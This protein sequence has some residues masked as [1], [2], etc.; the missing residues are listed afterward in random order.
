MRAIMILAVVIVAIT[1]L[2]APA[3]Q[4][5]M[6]RYPDNPAHERS[7]W[8]QLVLS[9][10][11]NVYD[12]MALM[13]RDTTLRTKK[14]RQLRR[15]Q[16]WVAQRR[17]HAD[18]LGHVEH[19]VAPVNDVLVEHARRMKMA[20]EPQSSDPRWFG[21]GPF[22]WDTAA[23]RATGS[24]GIGVVRS[25]IVFPDDPGLVIAGTI[26]A[27]I[28]RSSNAGRDW[29]PISH[30]EPI[31]TVNKLAVSG[32]TVYAATNI[33]LY[34][35]ADRGRTFERLS[36]SGDPAVS[37]VVAVD[38]CTVDPNDARRV[39]I[40]AGSRL[41]LSTDAGQSW[42]SASNMIGTWWDLCW[43]PTRSD[44]AYGLVQINGHIY[45]TRSTNAGVKFN[46]T[47]Q[48]YPSER[49]DARMLRALLAVTPANPR[50]VAVMIG[51]ATITDTGGVYG[52]YMSTD[53]GSTFEHRCCGGV[54]GPETPNAV[55]N[56]NLFDYDIAG[57]GLGQITWDMGFAISSTDPDFMI[58]AGIFPYRS[59]DGGRTWSTL[60]AMHYDVQSVSINGDSVW[61]THDGGIT[62]SS[63]RGVSIVD[64]SHGISATEVW[65]FDQSIDGKVMTIGAYHMPI[66]IR[67]TTV[68]ASGA[69]AYGWYPWSGADAMGT[70]VNPIA[71]EWLYAK[72][73][74]SVR[75]RRSTSKLLPPS[76]ADLGIDLGYITRDNICFDPQRY[77]QITAADHE[78]LRLVRS[79][80]NAASWATL[81]QFERWIGRVRQHPQQGRFLMC[82]GDGALWISS[83][84]GQTWEAITPPSGVML[85]QGM[86]DMA[87]DDDDPFHLYVAFG[88]HQ[89]KAK[90]AESTDG[91]R[92][93][94]PLNGELP[95]FTILTLIAR[96]GSRRE[97]YVGTTYGVYRHDAL[98]GWKLFGKDLPISDVSFL[99]A[100]ERNGWLRIGTNRGLWQ[101]QLPP[102]TIPR[103]QISHDI[104]TVRCSLS[105]VMFGCRSAVRQTSKFQR[106]WLFPGG[107]PNRSSD[108]IVAVTYATPGVYDAT[109]IVANEDGADTMHLSQAVVVLR[110]ECDSIDPVRGRA[111]DLSNDADHVTLGRYPRTVASF[112]FMAW[113]K[114]IGRQPNFSAIFCT[115]ADPNVAQEI[116][117]QFANDNNELGY[118]WTGGRWWWGSSLV[119]RPDEWSHVALTID[120]T[121]ATVYVNGRPSKDNI[122]LAPID[123]SKLVFTLGTY[124]Y[125]SSRNF[126]GLIDEVA[127]YDRCLSLEEVRRDMH[128]TKSRNDA[129]LF[130]YFQFN[131][132]QSGTVWDKVGSKHGQ[133]NGGAKNI[134]S[135]APVAA[136]EAELVRVPTGSSAASF[137]V[138]KDSCF[139]YQPPADSVDLVMTRFYQVDDLAVGAPQNILEGSWRIINAFGEIPSVELAELAVSAE[140]K[141]MPTQSG[142]RAWGVLHRSGWSMNDPWTSARIVENASL[143]LRENSVRARADRGLLT[144]LQ[145]LLTYSGTPASVESEC[146][147]SVVVSP[148]PAADVL[149]VRADMELGDIALFD[150]SGRLIMQLA[151]PH[152]RTEQGV[153]VSDLPNGTYILRA[154]GTYRVITVL[155]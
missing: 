112:T 57:T 133:H 143:P 4:S 154:G 124:H 101:A 118:L 84:S 129:G 76:A 83:N 107:Q 80:D 78:Q 139:L 33:G 105:P 55:T 149:Y 114:P 135:T 49:T 68:Y 8:Y 121:G 86:V 58:A 10:H 31:Q 23:V 2:V 9:D 14:S 48:G 142:S 90:V 89:S 65:G 72:P 71:T 64:R 100:D 27:G 79:S 6:S 96:R 155:R 132:G 82:L 85:G 95:P 56:P 75:A 20:E 99:H 61:I 120:S 145:L 44:I 1:P 77:T 98:T 130:G 3:Q 62:F 110:S 102:S 115:D 74:G 43:H 19:L 29:S 66:F 94:S 47:G 60:P 70:N 87:F 73:W 91:G 127:F 138:L 39:V 137:E 153:D 148:Q 51:G 54:D 111:V 93:W 36:L 69:P 42:K 38:L 134:V 26:S 41:F 50:M 25:H 122:R 13:Q 5:A 12:V 37:Q 147:T 108:P 81:K 141:F 103:A 123:L 136:G 119:V 30:D 46:P 53:D 150:L 11:H 117:L 144:P 18:G 140:S 113:V 146:V 40:A 45:F 88:G 151:V 22:G 32:D 59:I 109:L 97:L 21:I 24:Q 131:E 92:T 7:A 15:A 152:P 17:P 116:G 28:W 126:K 128:R 34:R 67:D 125:W 104:D 16:R 35:S 63:D 106:Q 52:L